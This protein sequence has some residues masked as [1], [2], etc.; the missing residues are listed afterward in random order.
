M[1][2]NNAS[3]YVERSD[4]FLMIGELENCIKDLQNALLK[5]P[6]DSFIHYKLGLAF[7]L[8]KDF[9][10]AIFYLD[11]SLLHDTQQEN[12]ADTFYHLG[13]ALQDLFKYPNRIEFRA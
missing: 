7:Y 8:T 4:L 12:K 10:K 13:I 9:P 3:F 11:Q 5:R 1:D 2:E 6:E